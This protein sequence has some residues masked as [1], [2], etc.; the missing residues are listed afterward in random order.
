M[1]RMKNSNNKKLIYRKLDINDTEFLFENIWSDPEICELSGEN[2]IH[3]SIEQSSNTVR[4]YIELGNSGIPFHTWILIDKKS[5]TRVGIMALFYVEKYNHLE[6]SYSIARKYWNRGYCTEAIEILI[7]FVDVNF[8]TDKLVASHYARNPASGKVL[9]K[10]GFEYCETTQDV[11]PFTGVS[12]TLIT[13]V[14]HF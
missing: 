6:I 5:L 3:Q 13:Y 7:Q 10:N 14:Y 1:G 11:N 2:D 4:N 8:N 12:E 9:Q